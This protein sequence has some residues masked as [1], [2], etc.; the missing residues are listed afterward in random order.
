MD[1]ESLVNSKINNKMNKMDNKMDK[2]D[3]KMDGIVVKNNSSVSSESS[4]KTIVNGKE[5]NN[6]NNEEGSGMFDILVLIIL[7]YAVYQYGQYIKNNL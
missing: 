7:C 6:E 3:N 4:S 5:I 1:T 2:M